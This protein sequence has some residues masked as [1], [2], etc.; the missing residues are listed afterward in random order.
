LKVRD[1]LKGGRLVDRPNRFTLRVLTPSGVRR[2]HL[3]DPGRLTELMVPGAPVV[4]FDRPL[5]GRKTDCEV[6]LIW[7][8]VWTVVNS[9][10]HS[11]L[12]EE[13]FHAL[14]LKGEVKREVKFGDSRVDFLVGDTLV[15][16]KGCTLVRD[17]LALFPDAPTERGRR[18]VLNLIRALNSGYKAMVLFLVMRP[19][20]RNLSPNWETD[21]GFS[22]AL[23]KAVEAGVEVRAIKFAYFPRT[24]EVRAL[25]TIPV[26]V[27]RLKGSS[28]GKG[29]VPPS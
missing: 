22:E 2:C 7:R 19:D 28:S 21:P 12:A 24:R 4:L 8:G 25:G 26:S 23:V 10:L 6:F 9:G 11:D 27:Q 1:P 20:A 18:H 13:V 17:G 15:E 16:V 5:R 14:G 29:D 3:R